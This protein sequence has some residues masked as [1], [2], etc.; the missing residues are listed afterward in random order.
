MFKYASKFTPQNLY[1][2]MEFFFKILGLQPPKDKRKKILYLL[3]VIPHISMSTFLVT[4][5][6]WTKLVCDFQEDFKVSML[7][8]SL[9]TL[10][11]VFIFR[12]IVWFF[13]KEKFSR[14][15]EVVQRDSFEFGCF[16]IYNIKFEHVLGK[17]KSEEGKEKVLKY[18]GLGELWKKAKISANSSK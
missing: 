7:T 13:T 4:G 10:H 12:I 17:A 15:A 14:I 8:L 11:S 2:W 18:S 16:S 9:C 1:T 5:L 3:V 6:E